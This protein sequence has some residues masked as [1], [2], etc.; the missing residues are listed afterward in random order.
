MNNGIIP[1]ELV[2]INI[3][4]DFA[5]R[6]HCGDWIGNEDG[7]LCYAT[8]ELAQAAMTVLWQAQGGTHLEYVVERYNGQTTNKNGDI[9]TQKTFQK[10]LEDYERKAHE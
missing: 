5:V 7:V 6:H 9:V 3:P 8:E 4:G 10:A 1:E 2:G